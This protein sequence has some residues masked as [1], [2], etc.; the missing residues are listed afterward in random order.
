MTYAVRDTTI[1][2]TDIK[3]GD[4]IAIDDDGLAAATEDIEDA[5]FEMLDKMD[6]SGSE[7]ITVYYGED[8]KDEDAEDLKEKIEERFPKAEVELQNGGQP[9]YYYIVSVE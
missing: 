6:A 9:V 7:I 2:G 8:V 5:V 3:K 1:D 4:Y